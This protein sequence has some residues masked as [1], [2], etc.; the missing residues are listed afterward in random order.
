M[1]D[2]TPTRD[3]IEE[4]VA[5]EQRLLRQPP[6]EFDPDRH[7]RLQAIAA[8][9][10]SCWDLLRRREAGQRTLLTDADVPDPPNELDGPDPEPTHLEHGV[11]GQGPQPDPEINPNVP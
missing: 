10:D 11:H 4:L 5:E 6:E 2:E 1:A 7:E 3:R 9:L 8:E